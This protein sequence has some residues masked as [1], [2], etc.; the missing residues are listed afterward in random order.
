[1][2]ENKNNDKKE[3]NIIKNTAKSFGKAFTWGGPFDS[4]LHE[5]NVNKSTKEFTDKVIINHLTGK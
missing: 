2:S 5:E 3:T 4:D 1:M